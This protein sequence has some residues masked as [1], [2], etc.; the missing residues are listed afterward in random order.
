MITKKE[1]LKKKLNNMSKHQIEARQE[2]REKQRVLTTGSRQD[3]LEMNSRIESNVDM[4][5]SRVRM[6]SP[7]NR[8]AMLS[9]DRRW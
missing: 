9:S 4:E 5:V 2:W 3:I 7:A 8:R 1:M 6:A